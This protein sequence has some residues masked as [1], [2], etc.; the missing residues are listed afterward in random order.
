[1]NTPD[2]I[3]EL[4]EQTFTIKNYFHLEN[5]LSASSYDWREGRRKTSYMQVDKISDVPEFLRWRDELVLSLS[6]LKKD[7]YIDEVIKLLK[8]FDGWNDKKKF[9]EVESKLSVLKEHIEEYT[10]T[11]NSLEIM[12]ERIPEKVLLNKVLRAVSKLQRNHS[13]NLQSDENEMND[14]IRDILDETFETKDQT[15][16]G[17]SEKESDAGE[18]D[19]QLYIDGIPGVMIE[20]LILDSVSKDY[21]DKHI[22]KVLVNYDPNG[23]PYAFLIIYYK[24][25]NLKEFYNRL[26]IHLNEFQFPYKRLAEIADVDVEYAELKH[27]QT[28]LLRNDKKIRVHFYVVHIV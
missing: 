16:Q 17:K 5:S 1:M 21:L 10:T 18:V 7:A 11:S 25:K 2:K 19:I 4:I 6:Q 22:R 8:R 15:R 13:Y 3:R 9:E 12:D 20:G 26:T 27:A 24:G 14:Y 23:C 28:I